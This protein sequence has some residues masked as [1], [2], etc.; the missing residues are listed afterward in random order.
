MYMYVKESTRESER[1]VSRQIK[2]LPRGCASASLLKWHSCWG[3]PRG[4]VSRLGAHVYTSRPTIT[5][6]FN[7][8]ITARH[9]PFSARR[10][11]PREERPPR[12]RGPAAPRW[13]LNHSG[14][15]RAASNYRT[16]CENAYGRAKNNRES[17]DVKPLCREF[18][19]SIYHLQRRSV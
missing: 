8:L 1:G 2:P 6:L 15:A 18:L 13:E 17:G 11:K 9:A 3:S 12:L 10:R 4:L 7:S 16:D 5:R 19:A 14:N